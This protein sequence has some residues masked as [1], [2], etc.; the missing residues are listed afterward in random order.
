MPLTCHGDIYY[1]LPFSPSLSRL[2]KGSD[3]FIKLSYI[4][5]VTNAVFC[6]ATV[7]L[8]TCV[9]IPPSYIHLLHV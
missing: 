6:V 7:L 9:H 4:I 5:V 1:S 3:V 2:S 8:C